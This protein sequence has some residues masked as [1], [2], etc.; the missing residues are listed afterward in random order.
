MAV[1][2]LGTPGGENHG[3]TSE[4]TTSYTVASGSDRLLIV[5]F[6][7]YGPALGIT[8]VTYAGSGMTQVGSTVTD[9][10]NWWLSY[11][12]LI[13]PT[14]GNN[15]L[16]ITMSGSAPISFGVVALSG[17]DQTT[18]LRALETNT[19]SSTAPTASPASEAGDI[20]V[21]FLAEYNGG[22]IT[23]A[24]TLIFESENGGSQN[25]FSSQ[26]LS[27]SAGTTSTDWT[28]DGAVAWGVLAAAVTSAAGGGGAT[29]VSKTTKA[30]L[31]GI[32]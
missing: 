17:V 13:A 12:R 2:I 20:V 10:S 25:S 7:Y 5:G 23:E 11:W 28:L 3:G 15:A 21:G 1:A 31:L 18:P 9:G 14:E 6:V 30:A 8:S 16:V 26:Y 19:G 27:G 4:I 32:G 24:G 29:G 22:T